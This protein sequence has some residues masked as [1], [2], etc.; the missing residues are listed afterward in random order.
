ML[1]ECQIS[2][3][4]AIL[5]ALLQLPHP[6]VPN[7][8]PAGAEKDR[9]ASFFTSLQHGLLLMRIPLPVLHPA[10]RNYI[11]QSDRS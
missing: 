2:A 4:I 11:F 7:L 9:A 3:G 6:F 8:G 10:A 1:L 5:D